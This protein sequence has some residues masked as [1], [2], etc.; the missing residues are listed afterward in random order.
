MDQGGPSGAHQRHLMNRTR[1]CWV[2]RVGRSQLVVLLIFLLTGLG[3]SSFA[4]IPRLIHYQG[5]LTEADGQPLVGEHTVRFR[6]YDAASGGTVLWEEHHTVNFESVDNGVFSI[7]LGSL[8]SFSAL[9][10]TQP[11]WLSIEVDGEGEM[12]PRQ[13]LAAIL[14]AIS[15]DTLDGLEATQLLRADVD[16]VAAG[17]LKLTKSGAALL[18][19]PLANPALNTTLLDVQDVTGTS[20][21]SVDLEGD[22]VIAGDLSVSGTIGGSTS[23]TGTESPSWTIG[24]GSDATATNLSLLFGQATGQ[25]SILFEGTGRDEFVVSDDVRLSAQAALRLEDDIGGDSISL[26]APSGVTTH[27]LTLPTA[28]GNAGQIL[29]TDASGNLFWVTDATGGGGTVT[30]VT[31]GDGL[32]ATPNPITTSGTIAL[33]ANGV[34]T[35]NILD[36]T[37]TAADLGTD[38]VGAEELTS[39]AIQAGDIEIADLPAH[40]STHQPG[41]NDGLVTGSAVSISTTNS[42]GSSTSLARAD[43]GHQGLHSLSASGQPQLAG[44]VTVSAGSNI[45]LTQAANDIQIAATAAGQGSKVSASASDSVSISS[46]ADTTLLSVSITKSQATSALLIVAS[47]QLNHTSGGNKT[48]DLKLFRDASQLDANYR[49]RIGSGGGQIQELPTTLHFWDTSGV[50]TYTFTLKARASGSGAQATIRRLT[51]IELL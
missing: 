1:A 14:Y 40:A 11:F 32:T 2:L 19:Q 7:L 12:Q 45:T 8:T 30:S 3:G 44:D 47:V 15:A 33:A 42:A 37:I 17:Q 25:E 21:F 48:V 51:V 22:T 10:F 46:S 49:A 41:G 34:T 13:R 20:R 43:H 9:D 26:K 5:R 38:S 50:G 24:S 23:T 16:T 39:T 31:A 6:L 4:E 18:I 36:G 29:S 28:L 27:T 35:A